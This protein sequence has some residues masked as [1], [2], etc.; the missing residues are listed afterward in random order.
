MSRIHQ[1]KM[2]PSLFQAAITEKKSMEVRRN[3]SNF[4]EGDRIILKEYSPTDGYTGSTQERL[5][6]YVSPFEP[7]IG[8][9]SFEMEILN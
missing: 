8:Y 1:L 3:D 2:Y 5:I 4:Q 9:I 7:K 6:T